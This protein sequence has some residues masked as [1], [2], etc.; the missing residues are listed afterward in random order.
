MMVSLMLVAAALMADP[1]PGP[2]QQVV[3]SDVTVSIRNRPG[4]RI[5]EI[6]GEYLIDASPMEVRNVLTD[7]SYGAR[8]PYVSEYQTISRQGNSVVR[9]TH[10]SLPIV[11]DRDWYIECTRESDLA[12]DGSGVYRSSWKPWGADIPARHNIVRVTTNEG[13]WQVD[14]GVDPGHARITYYLLSDPGGDIPGWVINMA[15]RKMLPELLHNLRKE[16]L[17]RR[18]AGA[19]AKAGP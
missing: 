6:K 10:L 5:Q 12:P 8:A 9:Y 19:V 16:I 4:V 14:P 13:Y 3:S 17:R 18:E 11:A 7:P 15:N 2:W 1:D